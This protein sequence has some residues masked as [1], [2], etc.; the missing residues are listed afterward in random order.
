MK[1]LFAIVVFFNAAT[2]LDRRRERDL[3]RSLED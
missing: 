3:Y 2:K 1:I